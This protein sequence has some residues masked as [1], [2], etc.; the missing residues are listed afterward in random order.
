MDFDEA[1]K[2]AIEIILDYDP[3]TIF[4]K[5]CG[6]MMWYGQLTRFSDYDFVSYGYKTGS[7]WFPGPHKRKKKEAIDLYL[8]DI[9]EVIDQAINL[10]LDLSAPRL[11]HQYYFY[12]ANFAYKQNIYMRAMGRYIENN[13]RLFINREAL[14]HVLEYVKAAFGILRQKDEQYERL[15]PAFAKRGYHKD[16]AKILLMA[17]KMCQSIKSNRVRTRFPKERFVKYIEF[18]Q[19]YNRVINDISDPSFGFLPPKDD[20]KLRHLQSYVSWL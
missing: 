6:S 8:F 14:Q 2:R 15:S 11:Y 19:L 18:E 17:L 7:L 9:R 20:Q 13:I 16:M 4:I 10:P 3:D 12:L 5:P 1:K